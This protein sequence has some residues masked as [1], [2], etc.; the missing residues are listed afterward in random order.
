[1]SLFFV[2]ALADPARQF[3]L[4]NCSTHM[5]IYE[6]TKIMSRH[7]NSETRKLQLQSEIDSRDLPSF[8][9]KH[10]I[11]DNSLGLTKLVDHIN[12]LAPQLPVGFGNEIYKTRYLCRAVMRLEWAQQP[13]SQVATSKYTFIQFVTALQESIQLLEK[14][15]ALERLTCIMDNT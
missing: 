7:Y 14:S 2:T 4:T 8:M 15:H 5:E 10:Q 13:I 11:T 3:F 9:R 1:M 12:A 6:I